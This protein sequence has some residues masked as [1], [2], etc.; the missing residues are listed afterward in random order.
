MNLQ[1]SLHHILTNWLSAKSEPFAGHKLAEF[2]RSD[3][4]AVIEDLCDDNM[5]LKGSPGQGNWADVPWLAIMHPTIT[6]STTHGVY[7]VYLFRSDASGVYLTLGQGTT[8]PK[9]EYGLKESR[10]KLKI[11]AKKI[12][13]Q[14]PALSGWVPD[15]TD[16]RARTNLGKSYEAPNIGFK[17]YETEQLPSND[18][19]CSDLDQLLKIYHDVASNW[20]NLRSLENE[21]NMVEKDTIKEPESNLVA[22][23][24]RFKDEKIDALI[25][26]FKHENPGFQTFSNAGDVYKE[27]E[28]QYKRDAVVLF[29][30][31]FGD[32]LQKENSY[33]ST[34]DFSDR[35]VKIFRKTNLVDWRAIDV[36]KN[37]ISASPEQCD[38]FKEHCH[39][40][41]SKA[42]KG[43]PIQDELD[44]FVDY[45]KTDMN[46]R[47]NLSRLF[48][49]YL[50]MLADP[51]SFIFIKPSLVKKFFTFL[52]RAE[53]MSKGHQTAEEY[54]RVLD[55]FQEIKNK[56]SALEPRD[57]I[58]VQSFYFLTMN[59]QKKDLPPP[60]DPSSSLIEDF[61][62]VLSDSGFITCESLAGILPA[63]LQTK[64]F[65]I[66]TGLSGSGK[67]KLAQAFSTWIY[68]SDNQ[69]QLVA[70]GAD[71]TSN[72]NLLGYPDALS[73]KRYR[74]PDNGAL[75]LIQAA[76]AD[77]EHPYFLILDEMNLSHVERYFADF[78]S[79]M[80][81]GEAMQLHAGKGEL[82]DGVPSEIKI[83]K[84]LFVIGTVNVDETTYM[85]SPKVLDRA[86]VIEFRVDE[87]E[88]GSFLANPVKPDLDAIAGQGAGYGKAFVAAAGAEVRLDDALRT[89]VSE[90]LMKFFPE[91]QKAGA[92]FG[93]RSAHEICR[94]VYFHQQLSG[95]EWDFDAAM[96]AAVMQKLLP[97]LHGAQRKLDSILDTL[98]KLCGP[99][100]PVSLAKIMRMKQRL[101]EQGFTSFAEA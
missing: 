48:P 2:I 63:A 57:F 46:S 50:L 17:F 67:T 29:D 4:P 54:F 84:N 81:S 66:L 70:V 101:H 20:D 96:D 92:E 28:D 88:M 34:T 90:V 37:H 8:D 80:E 95:D 31:F 1:E 73:P 49:S 7:P 91:L 82:W 100:Y 15:E 72:E 24:P 56:L 58:D 10:T 38:H 65:L 68:E 25:E 62:E 36:I 69:V 43:L 93:Y 71:W 9:N 79:A 14:I 85:F 74:K 61:N 44:Q 60:I 23:H 83:P 94:F 3:F 30:E 39:Q 64:P 52:G 35:I 77:P 22:I 41:L 75:D 45:V 51:S 27:K 32:W 33:L 59:A 40:L 26:I 98:E 21:G 42:R 11:R 78:L 76:Q 16:L 19:L 86:N 6:N 5:I 53:V 89:Q 47:P 12:R 97:K 99:S 18:Q 55:Y 87:D 13:D